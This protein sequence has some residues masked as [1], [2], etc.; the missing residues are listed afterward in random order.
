MKLAN[1]G[2]QTPVSGKKQKRVSIPQPRSAALQSLLPC[3]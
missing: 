2:P 1:N 3:F